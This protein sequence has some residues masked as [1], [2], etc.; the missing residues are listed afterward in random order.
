MTIEPHQDDERRNRHEAGR[1]L[2]PKRE[3]AEQRPDHELRVLGQH[4]ENHRAAQFEKGRVEPPPQVGGERSP[5]GV[6]VE[7]A[8]DIRRRPD[9]QQIAVRHLAVKPA[10]HLFQDQRVPAQIKHGV[11]HHTCEEDRVVR[12][13]AAPP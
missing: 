3:D 1:H 13:R 9:R 6:R 2:R 5:A 10:D 4:E 8:D 7:K 12:V 11:R